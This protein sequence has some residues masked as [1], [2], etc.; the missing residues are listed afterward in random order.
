M[1]TNKKDIVSLVN[2]QGQRSKLAM[3]SLLVCNSCLV[4]RK[5]LYNCGEGGGCMYSFYCLVVLEV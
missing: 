5:N 1:I 2:A 3:H 4:T